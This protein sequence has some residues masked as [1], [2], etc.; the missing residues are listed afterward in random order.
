MHDDYLQGGPECTILMS[1]LGK[2]SMPKGI[3]KKPFNPHDVPH[4]FW[5][6][7]A[8]GQSFGRSVGV[9]PMS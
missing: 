5:I 4:E 6:S 9:V 2:F 1:V 7:N 8:G 3:Q